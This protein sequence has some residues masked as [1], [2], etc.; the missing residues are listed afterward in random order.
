MDFK[1]LPVL[2]LHSMVL[3]PSSEIRLEFDSLEEKQLISLSEGGFNSHLLVV[4]PLLPLDQT[5][6]T[7]LPDVAVIG[8]IRMRIDMPNGKTRI[9][10]YG[11]RR[12]KV[13][14]YVEENHILQAEIDEI[15]I[16]V[17]DS[18]EEIAH[19]RKMMNVLETYV[20][21]TDYTNNI[22]D[23]LA[24]VSNL[25]T[26]TDLIAPS[27]PLLYQRQLSYIS[28]VDAIKRSMMIMEDIE[29]D[30]QILEIE[31]RC[32]CISFTPLIK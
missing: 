8:Q 15:D 26:M 24:G 16:V 11:V 25:D 30:I 10:I 22:L 21:T 5:T 7:T 20:D 29:D 23:R 32:R 27:L 2:L 14:S 1:K 28:T 18:K 3:F 17:P 13:N 19:I 4:N 6:A 9:S 31:K 12:V